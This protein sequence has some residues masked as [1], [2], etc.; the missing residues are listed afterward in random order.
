M[1]TSANRLRGAMYATAAA[2]RVAVHVR[3]HRIGTVARMTLATGQTARQRAFYP[4]HPTFRE[5]LNKRFFIVIPAFAEMTAA[6][7]TFL[8][9]TA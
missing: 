3:P 6:A 7:Q 2:T 1:L 9:T 4:L 8:R 5:Y